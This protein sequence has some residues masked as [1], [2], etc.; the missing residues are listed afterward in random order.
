MLFWGSIVS[1]FILERKYPNRVE[2]IVLLCMV[3]NVACAFNYDEYVT[4]ISELCRRFISIA[5]ININKNVVTILV[6]MMMFLPLGT[7]FCNKVEIRNGQYE[8]NLVG[9]QIR[10]DGAS[11]NE[12]IFNENVYLCAYDE[13]RAL[14]IWDYLNKNIKKCNMKE[15]EVTDYGMHIYKLNSEVYE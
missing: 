6:T 9:E 11:I 1:Y 10:I 8:R 14:K 2:F 15:I 7:I 3:L 12:I 4:A 5:R 13:N